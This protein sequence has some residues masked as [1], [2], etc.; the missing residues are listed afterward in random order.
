[1]PPVQLPTLLK[2]ALTPALLAGVQ[3]AALGPLLRDAP[4]AAVGLLTALPQVPRFSMNVMSL[5]GAQ[6]KALG[7]AW[8]AALAAAEAPP[9]LLQHA[10]LLS[11]LRPQFQC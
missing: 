8:D 2:Q 11:A 3:A 1:M 9:L 5:T 6:K 7:A 4:D 10:A